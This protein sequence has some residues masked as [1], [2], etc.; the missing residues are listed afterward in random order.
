MWKRIVAAAIAIILAAGGLGVHFGGKAAAKLVDRM[1]AQQDVVQGPVKYDRIAAGWSGDVQIYNIRW[2]GV[3]GSKK[4]EI[5]LTTLSINLWE[6]LTKGGGV[7]SINSIVLDHPHFYGMYSQEKGLDILHELQFSGQKT[8][9]AYKPAEEIKPTSFRGEIEIKDGTF[10]LLA[11]AKP[12]QFTK[13]SGQGLFKQYPL[14]QF[15]LT[16]VSGSSALVFNIVKNGE[17][18][19]VK[20]EVKNGKLVD[21]VPFLPNFKDIELKDG[22]I[23]TLNVTASKTAGNQWQFLLEGQVKEAS[24]NGFGCLF[25]AG[26]GKFTATWDKIALDKF[27]CRIQEMPL[28]ITGEI[29]TAVGLPDPASYDLQVKIPQ[30][31]LSD[32]SA[33]LDVPGNITAQGRITGSILEPKFEGTIALSDLKVG[34]M[35]IPQLAGIFKCANGEL[36]LGDVQGSAAEGTLRFNGTIK[37]QPRTFS[38]QVQGIDLKTE[39]MCSD[40]LY[41]KCRLDAEL[42][43]ADQKDS[44]AGSGTFTV[45]EGSWGNDKVR[46]FHGKLLITDGHLGFTE[47]QLRKGFK[48]FDLKLDLSKE[49]KIKIVA[50][51]GKISL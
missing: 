21:F 27:T 29:K 17:D 38:L 50:K 44:A 46:N 1:L 28:E 16:A 31:K 19:K 13:I 25:N 33:G 41:G 4:A 2:I 18:S 35:Q 3:N 42:S 5:P 30:G 24:G 8:V 39:K 20:G 47:V 36:H 22:Q 51:D 37:L 48:I 6:T 14:L 26:S 10:D 49:K 9:A 34:P 15:N 7:A 32:L 43:G 12:V 23:P 45:E 11:G 40:G